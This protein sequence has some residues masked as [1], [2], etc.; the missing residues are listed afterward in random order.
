MKTK[1]KKTTT[2]HSVSPYLN[3]GLK[4]RPADDN[5]SDVSSERGDVA[6]GSWKDQNYW[7]LPEN[8]RSAIDVANLKK[9]HSD[10]YYRLRVLNEKIHVFTDVFYD[11]MPNY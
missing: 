1:K 8:V 4:L 7:A 9:K 11:K 3:Q 10:F 2:A 6:E 5:D